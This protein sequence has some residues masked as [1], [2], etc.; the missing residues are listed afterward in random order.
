LIEKGGEL[1]NPFFSEERM[2][3]AFVGGQKN[4]TKM[5]EEKVLFSTKPQGGDIKNYF[6]NPLKS[7]FKIFIICKN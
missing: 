6:Q 1:E 7:Y 5:Y 4:T 3:L 2:Y